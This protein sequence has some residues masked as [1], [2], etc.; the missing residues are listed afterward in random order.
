MV[1]QK[2]NAE[3]NSIPA[4]IINQIKNYAFCDAGMLNRK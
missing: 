1:S 4:L 3:F 2:T